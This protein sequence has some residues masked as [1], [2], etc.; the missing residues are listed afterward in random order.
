MDQWVHEAPALAYV[1]DAATWLVVNKW[2]E[3]LLWTDEP[4]E[5]AWLSLWLLNTCQN[6]HANIGKPRPGESQ[7]SACFRT[8]E[9]AAPAAEVAAKP[10]DILNTYRHLS[11]SPRRPK[12]P[13]D[14]TAKA[15]DRL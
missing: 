2:G 11:R 4:A 14:L 12:R 15:L 13:R 5:V 6:A 7:T 10:M 3:P 8:C 1:K 9:R